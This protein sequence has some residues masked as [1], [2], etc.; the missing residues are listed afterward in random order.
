MIYVNVSAFHSTLYLYEIFVKLSEKKLL[1]IFMITQLVP[2]DILKKSKKILFITHLALGDFTYLQNYFQAFSEIYPHIKIHI[3]VDEVR[4]SNRAADW[5][6]LKKYALYDWLDASRFV[7]KIY[8]QT[9][10]PM[11]F[12]ESII[13]ARLQEYPLV[14]SLSTLRS[15]M[16]ASLAREISPY[17]F[18]VGI[19]KMPFWFAI[20]SC[21]VYRK[22]N[23][24]LDLNDT[25]Q[26]GM[27][28][29]DVYADWFKRLFGIETEPSSRFP[30]A[31]IPDQWQRYAKNQLLQWVGGK[32]TQMNTSPTKFIFINPFAKTKKRCWPLE[33][34]VELVMALGQS[35]DWSDTFFIVNVVPEKMPQTQQYFDKYAF[36]KVRLFSAEENFFQL[37]AIL[38]ECDLIIS[39]ETAV[40]HLANAVHVP[41]IALMRQKNPEW[42]PIDKENSIVITTSKR[43]DWVRA[44][45]VPQ[46]IH[47]LANL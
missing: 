19:K 2:S 22:L 8:N 23:A 3:W 26:T 15:P 37:P 4:R 14:V 9:Y 13:E 35:N 6:H 33:R 25:R 16:Y 27:H 10:S 24:T 17:G 44:I 39:V 1:T 30:F 29:S 18:V 20:G 36:D 45:T 46:V 7:A 21:L 38:A 31:N 40:M 12:Q 32:Y 41:V 42:V 34:V 5:E 47:V 43:S 28:I 11:L